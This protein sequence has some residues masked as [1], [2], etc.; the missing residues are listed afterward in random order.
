MLKQKY[1]LEFERLQNDCEYKYFIVGSPTN[2]KTVK[3][4]KADTLEELWNEL[5]S[6]DEIDLDRYEAENELFDELKEV[7]YIKN[8]NDY[9]EAIKCYLKDSRNF[10]YCKANF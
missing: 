7:Y 3:I 9:K 1:Q 2:L 10:F 6:M 8:P 5:V 4:V